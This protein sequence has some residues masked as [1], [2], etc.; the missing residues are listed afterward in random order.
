MVDPKVKLRL[1]L[2][3]VVQDLWRLEH[4]PEEIGS[5]LETSGYDRDQGCYLSTWQLWCAA[6]GE[7]AIVQPDSIYKARKRGSALQFRCKGVK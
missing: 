5:W 2:K 6:C 3:E 7:Y 1:L 4:P